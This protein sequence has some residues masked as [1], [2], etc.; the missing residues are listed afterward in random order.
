[1]FNKL[2]AV[3]GLFAVCATALAAIPDV[4]I[5]CWT[6]GGYVATWHPTGIDNGD[7]TY[8]FVGT[9]PDPDGDWQLSLQSMLVKSD[10]FISAVY[11]LTNN[12][13]T[14]QNF[15]LVVSI[16]VFPTITPTSLMGG[17]TGG[18]VTDSNFDGIGTIA[19]IATTPFYLGTI[20]SAG[21]LPLH[22]HPFSVSVP[23]AGG[24]ASI[25][26][27]SAGLPGPTLLGPA[28]LTDIGITHRFSL[29]SHDSAAISSFFVVTPE[30]TSLLLLGALAFVIRRR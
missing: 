14:T 11:G 27:V 2:I 17:S 10:P 1:M 8:S 4:R 3:L 18:S 20:D 22:P 16:P 6:D 12:A 19:T 23:F 26:A 5:D 15:T 28:V 13:A 30:P 25:P 29:T 24:T 9:L 7:G 21:A